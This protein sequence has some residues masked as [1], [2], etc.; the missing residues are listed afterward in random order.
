MAGMISYAQNFEDVMLA[1]VFHD[2]SGGFYIDVGAGDPVNM[3]VTKWFY[4]QGWSGINI[5]PNRTLFDQLSQARA[6]DINLNCGVGAEPGCARFLETPQPEL[7]TF[8]SRVQDAAKGNTGGIAIGV[9]IL[10]LSDIIERHAADRHIDFLKIDVEGWERN[11]LKGLDLDRHR[12]TVLVVE[13]VFPETKVE[14]H[15]EW[16]DLITMKKYKFVYFDGLNRFYL[17]DEANQLAHHFLLPPNVFDFITIYD[18]DVD[19][20]RHD[21]ER[22]L[23][24]I[25]TLTD[26]VKRIEVQR[27]NCE[28]DRA[29]RLKDSLTLT[30]EVQR[31]QAELETS[32]KD[33]AKRL[34]DNLTLAAAVGQLRAE[35]EIS[36][37]DRA[38]R[39]E[40]NLVLTAAV[41]R[42]QSD[43][44]ISEIDRA[45][46]HD[47]NLVLTAA[48]ERL[49]A[50]LEASERANV[51]R[52]NGDLA[53][54]PAAKRGHAQPASDAI[55]RVGFSADRFASAAALGR[56]PTFLAQ[57]VRPAIERLRLAARIEHL[58]RDEFAWYVELL[59]RYY[60]GRMADEVGL[61]DHVDALQNGLQ[62]SALARLIESSPE[63]ER[64]RQQQEAEAARRRV[65]RERLD[66]LSDGE[67]MVALGEYLF[68]GR[69][70]LAEEVEHGRQRLADDRANRTTLLQEAA[71]AF[72]A[73]RYRTE[74]PQN[75]P[76]YCWIMGTDRWLHRSDWEN[77]ARELGPP[78]S[79]A[80]RRVA[81]SNTQPFRHSGEFVV[82]A[83]ASLY[84]GR[85]YLETFLENIT[86][87]TIFDRSELIIIDADSPDG[88]G[89]I[90]SK[91]QK[92]FPNIVYKRINYRL[93][94]YDAWNVAVAMSR[95]K[96]LTNTNLDDLRRK[97]SLEIQA[98]SLDRYEFADVIYQDVLYSLDH[99]LPFE[100]IERFGFKSDLPIVTPH[101]LLKFN[102][103]HN[104]PMWRKSLH[105]EV[106]LFDT[107]YKSAGDWEF[108][109]RC[110]SKGKAFLKINTPHVVYFQNPD[111]IS[112]R[113]DTR[114]LE[115]GLRILRAYSDK[116][117]SQE[118]RMSRASFAE[119]LGTQ[120]DWDTTM[121]Y[122]DV[123]QRELSR[124]GAR[125]RQSEESADPS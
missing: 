40:D 116:V 107:S 1:R 16:E 32:E 39:H 97:D 56:F 9:D 25:R 51:L 77:R 41:E 14:T 86:S 50:D 7:S 28:Q 10:A 12:P 110:V 31:L 78:V 76:N 121:S 3:S 105:S 103:P 89:E 35:L 20:L 68:H 47:D 53:L 118:L 90:I 64:R 55:D 11:V 66:A 113:P 101:N 57:A 24:D 58:E 22:H 60:L 95:G 8:D 125:H 17:A 27:D 83:I 91:Y 6:R 79:R 15:S 52:E 75:D 23:A 45:K 62:P 108:W 106:G 21:R 102:S 80:G 99:S 73:T 120:A 122:Y 43:I 44:E 112:T 85:R 98:S 92:K 87:Q 49:Q 61:R 36:E 96:Y 124:L 93:G 46:R 63:A 2:R 65:H 82:S 13:A 18:P 111:G 114:G 115:E 74:T 88:E 29:Q 109:L 33:R 69:G 94:I 5:E 59:Y 26:L 4:D 30:A 48:M 104:A 117:V 119:A 54:R 34:E 84:K 70:A 38:K 67:F 37:K 72:V 42:L 81:A 19:R 123:V 71:E 100:E